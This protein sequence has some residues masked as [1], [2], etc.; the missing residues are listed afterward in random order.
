M[1]FSISSHN[2]LIV[3]FLMFFMSDGFGQERSNGR[4]GVSLGT[5]NYITDADFL[6][7][8]SGFGYSLGFVSI[9]NFNDKFYLLFE[10][11]YT[12]N[13]VKF[14]GKETLASEKQEDIKFNLER[15]NVPVSVNYNFYTHNDMFFGINGGGI[16]AFYN[17]YRL[18][19]LDKEEYYLEPYNAAPSTLDFSAANEK[20][21]VNFF[22]TLGLSAEYKS[23][24][25]NLNYNY[26]LTDP[27]RN[28]NLNREVK[29]HDS[30]FAFS[31][32]Y[33]FKEF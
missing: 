19:D 14:V 27:Y 2:L 22:A 30:Y 24:L 9:A 29:G 21:D 13:F 32:T 31:L 1:R 28:A 15:F 23:F 25:L 26:G 11:N 3:I 8:K 20:I 7:S 33:I 5:T 12:R 4:L 10:I 18:V 6:F 17:G 16:I